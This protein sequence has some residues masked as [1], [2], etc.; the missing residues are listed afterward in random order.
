MTTYG[1]IPAGMPT[2]LSL[3]CTSF[4]RERFRLS[5]GTR[6]PWKKMVQLR[7]LSISAN[8]TGAFQKTQNPRCLLSNKLHHH[9]SLHLLRHSIHSYQALAHAGHGR[10]WSK[11]GHSPFR[12]MLLKHSR[13]SR[14]HAAYFRIN[15][16]IVILFILFAAVSIPIPKSF[17]I[18][19]A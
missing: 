19:S 15:Y 13:K 4:A 7:S 8:A 18:Y 14:T 12:L 10:R 6:R 2:S 9:H 17:T 3:G 5:L 1:T 16:I 11:S